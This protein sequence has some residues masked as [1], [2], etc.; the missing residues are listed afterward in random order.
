MARFLIVSILA[1]L[2]CD[3]G[4]GDDAPAFAP[5]HT[6]GA[7][8]RDADGRVALLRG[9]N[10]RVDGVF[11]VSFDDGRVALESV[12]P[13]LAEDCARMRELGFNLLRLP[14]NWSGIEPEQGSIDTDYLARV[15]AAVD[16]AGDAGL[17]VL[18]DLH[19]DAYS[20][21]IGEDGAPLWAIVPPPDM[22]LEGPLEDLDARRTSEQ[23]MRAFETFFDPTDPAELQVAFI[24]MLRVVGAR[25]ADHPA[26]V[27]FELYNEPV[28]GAAELDAFQFAAAAAL[29]EVAPRKLVFFEPPAIRNFLDFQPLASEPFPVAGAVYSPHI[30]TFV[31]GDAEA[32]LA[33]LTKDALRPSVDNARAEADAWGTPLF[34]GEWG[35]GTTTTN[36][37]NW[38]AW[39]SELHDEM[40]ASSAFWLWKEES[41]GRWG[42]HD[43]DDAT[44]AWTERPQVVAWVSRFYPQRI[45][46]DPTRLGY[47]AA[48]ETMELEA[49]GAAHVIYVPERHAGRFALACDGSPVEAARDAATGTVEVTCAGTLTAR[50]Y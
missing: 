9:V 18:I 31:F 26:V 42:V 11:D 48:T 27:G 37:D 30:Y 38:I 41:Q 1:A 49:T 22:L 28:T 39:E 17:L 8:L 6:D 19:Q 2:A 7:H 15:D 16:C 14:V 4:G 5:L 44:G 45:D 47:D 32:Q 50:P 29:R 25:W 34:I 20:K 43:Y 36:A 33:A 35:I 12:P 24:D 13:L 3:G 46:G 10:A 21:E 40:F 23:V